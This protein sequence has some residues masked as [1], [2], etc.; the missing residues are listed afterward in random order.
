MD[1]GTA[2][3][4]TAFIGGVIAFLANIS[5][6]ASFFFQLFGNRGGERQVI[7]VFDEPSSKIN[8]ALTGA[9]VGG[10]AALIVNELLKSPRLIEIVPNF[11]DTTFEPFPNF[12]PALLEPIS[13][14][15]ESGY[16][17]D[18]IDSLTPLS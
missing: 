16:L 5:Q 18:V 12:D 15:P 11:A 9:A 10:G 1:S 7:S 4:L 6:I 3:A 8:S 13:V 17:S 2:I 14:I